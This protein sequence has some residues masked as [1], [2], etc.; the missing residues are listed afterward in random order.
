MVKSWELDRKSHRLTPAPSAHGISGSLATQDL[1]RDGVEKI[2]EHP[3]GPHNDEHQARRLQALRRLLLKGDCRS[4]V[5][6][7]FRGIENALLAG[8]G[9]GQPGLDKACGHGLVRGVGKWIGK[10]QE[11]IEGPFRPRKWLREWNHAF[12]ALIS[13]PSSDTEHHGRFRARRFPGAR[14]VARS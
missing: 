10:W 1:S 14:R 6:I 13:H 9:D 8:G 2:V 3:R 4:G 11:A 12:L 7:C 5:S